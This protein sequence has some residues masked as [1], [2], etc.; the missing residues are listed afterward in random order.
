MSEKSHVSLEQRA[1]IVCGKPYDTGALLLDRRLRASME[2]YTV[3][4][5][6]LCSEHLRLHQE[7]YIALVA[8]DPKK[9]GDPVDG[10]VILPEQVFRTGLIAHLKRETFAEIFNT[11]IVPEQPCVYVEPGVIEKLQGMVQ[12]SQ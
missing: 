4:G 11:T 5:W 6:G 7:G 3:T 9:S 12:P 1:C 10:A 2:K 8:C